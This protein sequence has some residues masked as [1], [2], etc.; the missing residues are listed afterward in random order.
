LSPPCFVVRPLLRI[1]HDVACEFALTIFFAG[2]RLHKGFHAFLAFSTMISSHTQR[3]YCVGGGN[4]M[5]PM[6]T[7]LTQSS[8]FIAGF[9]LGYA[10][11]AWRGRRRA[12][13]TLTS[14]NARA[15]TSMFGHARR[16]F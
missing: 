10:A 11:C 16:A 12:N 1:A 6:L 13:G 7:F 2:S 4:R 15:V 3:R 14:R 8:I 9:G 5:N